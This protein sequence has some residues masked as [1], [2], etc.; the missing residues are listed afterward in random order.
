MLQVQWQKGR[1]KENLRETHDNEV[2]QKSSRK[3]EEE[4]EKKN[5]NCLLLI[6]LCM[7]K[8]SS[9]FLPQLQ[10][11]FT[12]MKTMCTALHSSPE[13]FGAI[14]TDKPYYTALGEH[15]NDAAVPLNIRAAVFP[16]IVVE[17]S[18][19]WIL[20]IVAEERKFR[21][22]LRSANI[23][24]YSLYNSINTIRRT[25]AFHA[26]ESLNTAKFT[27]VVIS[28]LNNSYRE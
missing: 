9:M 25:F 13:E 12:W 8:N 28:I 7:I 2:L 26:S 19:K 23:L 5:T 22:I 18:Y 4:E 20:L 6:V 17:S 1:T 24:Q 16:Y 21:Y 14:A 27:F 3:E 10:D 15:K 11:S